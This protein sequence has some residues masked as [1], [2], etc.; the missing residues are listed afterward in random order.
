MAT[1]KATQTARAKKTPNTA[2]NRAKA[3]ETRKRNAEAKKKAAAK[4]AATEKAKH[5]ATLRQLQPV[6]K[7]INTRMEKANSI[8]AKAQQQAD[9]HRLA[10]S[11]RMAEAQDACKKAGI[12]FK[13]WVAE[14]L[15]YKTPTGEMKKL[16]YGEAIRLSSIGAS[17]DPAQ[18]LEDLRAG[19][20]KR[21]AKAAGKRKALA[22]ATVSSK[23]PKV[24][25]L[26]AA[27][28]A[29]A[30]LGDQGT[31]N[32]LTDQAA[33]HGMAVVSKT[34][35]AKIAKASDAIFGTE[36]LRAAFSDLKASEKVSFLEWA[37][38]EIGATLQMPDFGGEPED[39]G[40]GD[41]L[42]IPKAFRRTPTKKA[43]AKARKTATRKRS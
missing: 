2:G 39:T 30:A 24:S 4:A 35:A 10:A 41:A 3:A 14:H 23:G 16:S 7:E 18:A 22:S 31:V 12:T 43:G 32:L 26:E 9:D 42:E 27:E 15:E 25:K 21:V 40:T 8:E 13:R 37:C 6:A 1:R 33:K 34:E 28:T 38:A 36:T 11:L 17:S 20:R 5:T 19:T 29:L